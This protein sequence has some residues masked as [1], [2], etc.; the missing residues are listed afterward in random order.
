MNIKVNQKLPN[1]IGQTYDGQEIDLSRLAGQ[2][3]LVLYFYPKDDTPGC[4]LEG[5]EFSQLNKE[6]RKL[7][8]W[9]VGVSRDSLDSHQRFCHKNN[10]RLPLLSDA[11]GAYGRKLGLLKDGG[12]FKRTTILAGRD[13]KV[14]HIW[15]DVSASG[16]AVEVL[17]KVKEL[18][19]MARKKLALGR[20]LGPHRRNYAKPS[21]RAAA[22]SKFV[23]K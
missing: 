11:D 17:G 23:R 6:F 4:T 5:I 9:V 21:I 22:K 15:E 13:G 16:H 10:I 19:N 3:N 2:G 14:K 1:F 7:N 8:T 20:D 18:E 12:I